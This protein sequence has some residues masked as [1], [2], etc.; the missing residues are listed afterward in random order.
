MSSARPR[1]N[2]SWKSPRNYVRRNAIANRR[3]TID[4]TRQILAR[5]TPRM[6][7]F[8]ISPNRQQV[9]GRG[10]EGMFCSADIWPNTLVGLPNLIVLSHVTRNCSFVSGDWERQEYF[11]FVIWHTHTVRSVDKC[12]E[13]NLFC[14]VRF[15]A[16]ERISSLMI[17]RIKY[18]KCAAID[19]TAAIIIYSFVSFNAHTQHR[20]ILFGSCVVPVV[21]GILNYSFKVNIFVYLLIHMMKTNAMKLHFHSEICWATCF[22]VALCNF[23]TEQK[24]SLF[25]DFASLNHFFGFHIAWPS[26]SVSLC[27][28]KPYRRGFD[29]SIVRPSSI[30]RCEYWKCCQ[31]IS[32]SHFTM[33]RSHHILCQ[34]DGIANCEFMKLLKLFLRTNRSYRIAAT[35]PLGNKCIHCSFESFL[36]LAVVAHLPL[37]PQAISSWIWYLNKIWAVRCDTSD[38]PN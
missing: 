10:W 37:Q 19:T 12:I 8:A 16:V 31:F 14:S 30:V 15:A 3:T 34:I 6:T 33:L 20:N 11:L 36:S 2:I 9:F 29:I 4:N 22:D 28:H 24:S 35:R 17:F 21:A 5:I 26:P 38:Q 27:S 23:V 32:R 7:L 1:W 18:F 25:P 13:R